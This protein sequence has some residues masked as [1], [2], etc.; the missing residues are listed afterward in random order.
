MPVDINYVS[1]DDAQSATVQNT[2]QALELCSELTEAEFNDQLKGITAYVVDRQTH[3]PCESCALLTLI[4]LIG[5]ATIK[6]ARERT[7]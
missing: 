3:C 1:S 7:Q 4:T 6:A 2:Q 5:L